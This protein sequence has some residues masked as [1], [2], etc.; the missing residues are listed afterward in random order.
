[1]LEEYGIRPESA[2]SALHR[3]HAKSSDSLEYRILSVL[4]GNPMNADTLAESLRVGIS[5]I[6]V[7]LGKMEIFG[8]IARDI[9]GNYFANHG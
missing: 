3:S 7:E 4:D 6:Q 5:E 8:T 9:S 2:L 1:M